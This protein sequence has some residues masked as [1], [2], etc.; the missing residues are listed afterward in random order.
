M[1]FWSENRGGRILCKVG[2]LVIIVT[3]K[4]Y[5]EKLII[6]FSVFIFTVAFAMPDHSVHVCFLNYFLIRR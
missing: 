1:L 3:D 5:R 6:V 4:K 2:A